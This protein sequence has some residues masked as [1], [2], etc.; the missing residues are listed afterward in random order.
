MK[1][2]DSVG[3][4][5]YFTD[6]PQADEYGKIIEGDEPV[7]TPT[8]V[9]YEVYKNI[10]RNA[11]Q[12]PAGIAAAQMQATEVVPLSR[13]L[14]LVAASFSVEHKLPMADAIVYATGHQLGASVLTSD[15]H[16]EG[17]SGVEFIPKI[18]PGER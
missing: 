8:I 18:G 11:G 12:H 2:V 4:L 6:G 16:L 5:E 13:E 3:W 7:I 10:L 9:I 14:S 17:L 15:K 1:V